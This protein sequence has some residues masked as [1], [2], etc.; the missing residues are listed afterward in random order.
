MMLKVFVLIAGLWVVLCTQ[1]VVNEAIVVARHAHGELSV[2]DFKIVSEP[3]PTEKDLVADEVVLQVHLLSVDPYMRGRMRDT[4][5]ENYFVGAFGLSDPVSGGGLAKIVASKNDEF[6]VG[7]FVTGTLPWKRF[8][9]L[10]PATAGLTK[11]S[12]WLKTNDVNYLHKFLF[13]LNIAPLSAWLPIRQLWPRESVKPGGVA[14]VSGAA[15]AVGMIAGQILKKVYGLYVIGSAGSDEKVAYLKETLGF[16]EA[17]NYK[18]D[19]PYDALPRLAPNKINSFFDNVGGETLDAALVSMATNGKIIACGAIGQY[20]MEDIGV[21]IKNM[22]Q[23]VIQSITIQGYLVSQFLDYFAVGNEELLAWAKDGLL[24]T[25]ET[26]VDGFENAPSAFVGLFKGENVGKML[27]RVFNET[28]PSVE[29]EV[30]GEGDIK[31]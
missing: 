10:N 13:P 23:I 6:P 2:E 15:G 25:H 4:G 29:V 21:K 22:F 18:K 9:R 28:V 27:V 26:Y 14:Y 19:S 5:L 3:L 24:T 8:L 12:M 17:F 1:N 30:T 31:G 20:D 7:E 11:T 16:D